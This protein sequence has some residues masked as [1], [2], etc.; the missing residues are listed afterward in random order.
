MFCAGFTRYSHSIERRS[1]EAA[2]D[3]DWGER[4]GE[5]ERSKKCVHIVT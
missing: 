5:D 2:M 3:P 1:Q 4:R